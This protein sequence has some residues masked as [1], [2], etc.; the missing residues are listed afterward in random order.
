MTTYPTRSTGYS[1]SVPIETWYRG[2]LVEGDY[3][4][5]S[6]G[7]GVQTYL[8]QEFTVVYIVAVYISPSANAS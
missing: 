3:V 6:T 8:S 1:F 4:F 5:I 2:K 7:D